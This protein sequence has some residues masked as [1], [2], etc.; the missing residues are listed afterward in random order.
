MSPETEGRQ[1]SPTG[2]V[3]VVTGG[4]VGIGNAVA[5]SLAERGWRCAVIDRERPPEPAAGRLFRVQADVSDVE[6]VDRAFSEVEQQFGNPVEVLVC[7][8][9]VLEASTP[10]EDLEPSVWRHV[11]D[12]DLTGVFLCCRRVIPGMKRSGY[13]RIV[14]LASIAGK[15]GNP[16][17]TAY[18]AAK[19]GVI[20]FTKAL[21]K[22]VATDGITVNALAPALVDT[23]MVRKM[24]AA[25]RDRLKQLIPMRRVAATEEI[26]SAVSYLID[27]ATFST[28]SVLDASG[29]RA[30]Y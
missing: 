27:D 6:E 13:G 17:M 10:I 15:E 7:C 2:R 28:G 8:A 19:A 9:A 21:A 26:V 12:V 23:P 29:G 16:R 1:G 14:N 5:T 30:T 20:G 18:S 22:E 25:T 11:L 24:D 3:A 4:A